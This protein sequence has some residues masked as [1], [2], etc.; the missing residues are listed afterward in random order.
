MTAPP[1]QPPAPAPTDEPLLRVAGLCKTFTAGRF[2]RGPSVRAVDDVSFAVHASEVVALVGESGSGKSTIARLVARLEAPSAGRIWWRGRDLLATEPRAT[3]RYRGE[4]QMI[5][6]DPFAS[7]NPAH[8]VAHH[9]ARPLLLHR[10][11]SGAAALTAAI[12]QLL[13]TVGLSPAAEYA[14]KHPHA[15]SGGQRQRVG[16]ARALAPGPALIVADE[17][18][19]ML[20]VS[21]RAGILGL[22]RELKQ[23]RGLG[24]LYI[25]HDLGG[26]RAIADRTL[27]I[28]DGRI[29]EQGPTDAVLGAPAHP[30]TQR[31]LEALPR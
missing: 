13:D 24:F 29:V 6:Q 19:S 30:Y 1:A 3:L 18:T 7:L 11:A 9:L 20:D 25:T 12:H 26:A 27:V 10:Q 17:P 21:I 5:F 8:T 23:Q 16:I 28:K 15:L 14:A 2:G 4:L 31:L 22:L